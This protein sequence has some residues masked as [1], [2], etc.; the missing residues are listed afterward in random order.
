MKSYSSREI[1]KLLKKTAGTKST[2]SAIIISSNIRRRKD[3][4][5]SRTR[6]ETSPSTH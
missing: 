6:A 3:A 5:P 1:I 4:S 2:A